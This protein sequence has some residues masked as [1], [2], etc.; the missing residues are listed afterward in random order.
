MSRIPVFVFI[1]SILWIIRFNFLQNL[2]EW[3]SS[4]LAMRTAC[5]G[6]LFDKPNQLNDLIEVSIEASRMTHN[7]PTGE[8]LNWCS[9]QKHTK[10]KLMKFG[11]CNETND[12]F[13]SLWRIFRR[14]GIIIIHQLCTAR[15]SC[16][17]VG[18][19]NGNHRTS[20]MCGVLE[21]QWK[22]L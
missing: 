9:F 5:I 8:F 19:S 7:C 15:Y 12:S 21:N 16:L 18:A 2:T 6:L 20:K 22:R 1:C 17:W 3:R 11:C 14:N 4:F 10:T 13:P